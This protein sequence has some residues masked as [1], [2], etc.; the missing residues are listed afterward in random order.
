MI[1]RYGDM[2]EKCGVCDCLEDTYMM[3][4]K[5]QIDSCH[6]IDIL[7]DR[8][9]YL[10]GVDVL[11]RSL[12]L[13]LLWTQKQVVVAEVVYYNIYSKFDLSRRATNRP[14]LALRLGVT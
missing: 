14:Q 9:S 7:E 11:Q 10:I 3:F 13:V 6:V 5:I 12:S 8:Q 2:G 1:G 4:F